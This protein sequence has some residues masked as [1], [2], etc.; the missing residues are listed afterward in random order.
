MRGRRRRRGRRLLP[1]R[2]AQH[3]G[4]GAGAGADA[5]AGDGEQD[6]AQQQAG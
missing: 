1:V 3:A 2:H 6:G 5:D 4:A